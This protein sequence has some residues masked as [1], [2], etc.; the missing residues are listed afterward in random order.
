MSQGYHTDSRMQQA[1]QLGQHQ[2]MAGHL[3]KPEGN[4]IETSQH[5]IQQ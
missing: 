2:K 4:V 1:S 5:N 3:G